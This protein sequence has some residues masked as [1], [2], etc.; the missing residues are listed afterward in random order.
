MVSRDELCRSDHQRWGCGAINSGKSQDSNS[1]PSSSTELAPPVELGQLL[2]LTAMSLKR[3]LLPVAL[4]ALVAFAE[5]PPTLTTGNTTQLQYLTQDLPSS[6]FTFTVSSYSG[7]PQTQRQINGS[8]G[9]QPVG[10]TKGYEQPKRD[11]VNKGPDSN[12]SSRRR[13]PAMF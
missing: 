9:I 13:L 1:F 12:L 6:N 7:L 10:T 3:L 5:S 11:S 2:F 8:S 4:T